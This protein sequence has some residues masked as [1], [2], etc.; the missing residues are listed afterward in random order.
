MPIKIQ[1]SQVAEQYESGFTKDVTIRIP[2]VWTGRIS[3]ITPEAA[4]VLAQQ[5][6]QHFRK[7]AAPVPLSKP[8]P[9]KK[10]TPAASAE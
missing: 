4:E 3:Q 2:R 5:G 10:Q 7:K 9:E 8:S 6:N 1:N